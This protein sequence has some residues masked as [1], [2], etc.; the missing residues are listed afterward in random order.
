[1]PFWESL[2]GALGGG[3]FFFTSGWFFSTSDSRKCFF[4]TGT[5]FF[6]QY[7]VFVSRVDGFSVPF[8]SLNGSFSLVDGFFSFQMVVFQQWMFFSARQ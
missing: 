5:C 1:M 2:G 6:H 7:M 4:F 8:L 3:C